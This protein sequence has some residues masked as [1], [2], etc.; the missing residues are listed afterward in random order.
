MAVYQVGADGK[1]QTGLKSGDQVV[2]GGGVY[3]ITGVNPDGTYKTSQADTSY[4]TAEDTAGVNAMYQQVQA[5]QQRETTPAATTATPAVTTATATA[6]STVSNAASMYDQNNLTATQLAQI[7]AYKQQY[8]AAQASGNTAAA[9]SAHAAAEA[10]RASANYSGGTTGSEYIPLT[11]ETTSASAV[12]T[13]VIAPVQ[14][15]DTSGLQ[16]TLGQLVAA[17]KQQS[18]NSINYATQQSVVELERAKQDAAAQYQTERNQVS[19]DEATALDNQALYNEM[20]G[21]N[22][23]IGSAQY[24]AIQN[25]AAQNR[26]AVNQEQTKLSTDTAQQISDLRAQGEFE[27]ADAL[28]SITQSY[29]SDLMSLEQWATETN[30]SVDEFNAQLKEWEAEYNLSAQQYLSDLDLSTAQLT[31]TFSDGTQTLD[32]QETLNSRLASAGQTLLSMGMLPSDSQLEAMGMTSD[33]AQSYLNALTLQNASKSA[34]N[35]TQQSTGLDALFSAAWK[36]SGGNTTAAKNWAEKNAS[37]YGF[38][39]DISDEFESW[40][41]TN[42][43]ATTTDQMWKEA[44]GLLTDWSKNGLSKTDIANEIET[45]VSNGHFSQEVGAWLYQKAGLV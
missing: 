29:L 38:G 3:T 19:A 32:A 27:K 34:G 28:L 41:T 20:N 15:V 39:E 14:G 6:P 22:G 18:D 24:A 13:P 43:G 21:D 7:E 36:A 4:G 2:T 9:S 33:Q 8:E 25:T 40:Y 5:A 45:L 35:S 30:I 12:A 42:V 1:A 23:G 44:Q 26:L 11:Q 16:A 31:G 10:I 17:Q 37:K